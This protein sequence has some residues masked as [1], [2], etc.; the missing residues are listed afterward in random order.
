LQW[1]AALIAIT[2][3]QVTERVRATFNLKSEALLSIRGKTV[4]LKSID[5]SFTPRTR[6]YSQVVELDA[7]LGLY[8]YLRGNVKLVGGEN[9]YMIKGLNF[10]TSILIDAAPI[11]E[12]GRNL[13]SEETGIGLNIVEG[14]GNSIGHSLPKL[15]DL[16]LPEDLELK[17]T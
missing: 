12:G 17:I 2:N 3:P 14:L 13:G 6:W 16:V 11:F 10:D 15:E 9:K 4:Q 5:I 8:D 7:A 1:R